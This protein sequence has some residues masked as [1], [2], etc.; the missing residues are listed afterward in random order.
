MKLNRRKAMS[1]AV[2]ISIALALASPTVLVKA[3]PGQVTRVGE[4]DSYET[5]AV[6]ATTNWT[7]AKD[8]V[9]VCGEGYADAV[10][11]SVLAKQLDAPI[12][13]T[14]AASLNASAKNAIDKLKPQNIYII[15]GNASVSQSLRDGLKS[16]NYNLIELGGKDRYETNTAVAKQLIK[17]GAK[18]DNVI[19]VSGEGFSDILSATPI[20]AAKGQIILLGNNNKS[21]MKPVLDFIKSNNSSVTVIGTTYSINDNIYKEVGAVKRVSGGADRFETNLNVL[22]SFNNDLNTNKLFIANAS[23]DR[24]ADALIAS[25][26]A[27][28]WSAPLVLVDNENSTSTDKALSYIKDKSKASTDLNVIGGSTIVSDNVV[29][30]INESV[31]GVNEPTVKSVSANGLNQIKIV[32]NTEVDDDTAEAVKN[33]QIDGKDLGSSPETE[34]SATLQED[35]RTVLITLSK[36]FMQYKDVT[37]TIKNVILDR[38]LS[39]TIPKLEQKLTF[40]ETSAPTLESVTAVG[41]NKLVVKFSEPIKMTMS[42]LSSMKINRQS[43]TNY[44]LD[45]SVTELCEKSDVWSDKVELYFSSPLPTGN[46]VFTIPNGDIDKRFYNAGKFPIKGTSM[47]FNVESAAGRPEVKS[48]TGDTSG[49]IYI[50]YNRPMD[51]Q[52]AL[53]DSNYKINGVRLNVSS[54]DIKFEEGSNDTIVKIKSIGH[55]IKDKAN[56]VTIC[57]EI[58]DTYGNEVSEINLNLNITNDNVKPQVT[59]VTVLDGKTMRIKFNK[60]V[61]TGYATNKANYKL[62]D[63]DGTEITYKIDDI[64][65]V[66]DADGN[67]KRTYEI[68]FKDRD[69]LKGSKYT[70]TVRN[71]ID[72]NDTSNVMDVYTTVI[73]G[74]DTKAPS[75]TSIL[76]RQDNW[77]EVVIFFNKAMDQSTIMNP[78]NYYFI[79]GKGDTK[80]L[81][82][83]AVITPSGDGKSVS[84]EFSSSYTIGYGSS[85]VSVIKMGVAN[86]KDKDGNLLGSISYNDSIGTDYSNGPSLIEDTARL[87][88]DGNDIKVKVSLTAPLDILNLGDFR[89]AGNNP[90]SGIIVGNDLIL[91]YKSGVK[92]NEKINAIKNSGSTVTFSISNPTSVDAAGRKIKSGSESVLLPPTTV[93]NSWRAETNGSSGT[94]PSVTIVFDQNIDDEIEASYSDDFTF[95]NERTGESLEV[96]SVNV[97]DREVTYKFYNGSIKSGDKIDVRASSISNNISIRSDAHNQR[98]HAVYTP[99]SDDLTVKTLIAK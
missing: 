13:L 97:D 46:N 55:L 87:T 3:A 15:G 44:G 76:K 52:T 98:E 23:D 59:N 51:K 29:S 77:Q 81:P 40:F 33:Y 6:V 28:K 96:V 69:N 37:F 1:R 82:R 56:V 70:L 62:V 83:S 72:T 48:V 58:T 73:S 9:L 60:D 67:S 27:G 10:S 22:N 84:I 35:K 91:T 8:V 50:T 57:D 92:N 61:D 89:V 93:P 19:L 41:G 34:A 65:A 30:K 32:F 95:V 17:L 24:Y 21:T 53:E 16:N 66:R 39:N 90:D 38:K 80:K 99:T 94:N 88:Y 25:S 63:S 43:I 20:A 31:P 86:V 64:Y 36:P 2:A 68:K 74:L 47:N 14:Q 7:S 12:L 54:S 79:D 85:E 75:V 42:D 26:L 45:E 4:V 18:A 78:E 5:A 71:I 49:T 11:A